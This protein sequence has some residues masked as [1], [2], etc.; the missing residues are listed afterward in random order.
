MEDHLKLH[1]ID[2]TYQIRFEDGTRLSLTSDLNTLQEMVEGIEPGSFRGLLRF[3][4]EGKL[5]AVSHFINFS[6]VL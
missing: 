6:S 5:V 1:R 2:P 3:L 4:V